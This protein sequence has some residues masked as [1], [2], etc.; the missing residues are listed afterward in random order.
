MDTLVSLAKQWAAGEIELEEVLKIA[1]TLDYPEYREDFEGFYLE[2][3]MENSLT[4]VS[5]LVPEFLTNEQ[6]ETFGRAWLGNF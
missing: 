2:G 4:A 5:A 1:K 6:Y 3:E